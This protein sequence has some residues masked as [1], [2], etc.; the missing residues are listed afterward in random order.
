MHKSTKQDWVLHLNGDLKSKCI[1]CEARTYWAKLNQMN[2]N[3]DT[4][5][6][7]ELIKGALIFVLENMD[8]PV[9]E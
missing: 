2:P 7:I 9:S 1:D 5:E 6:N 3:I 8:W 4:Q